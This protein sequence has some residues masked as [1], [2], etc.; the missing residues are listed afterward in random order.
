MEDNYLLKHADGAQSE[1]VEVARILNSRRIVGGTFLAGTALLSIGVLIGSATIFMLFPRIGVGLFATQKRHGLAMAGFSERVEL[2]QHGRIRDN[3]QVVMRIILGPKGSPRRSPPAVPILWRGSVYDQYANGSWTHSSYVS[4]RPRPVY[5]SQGLFVMLD[6]APGVKQ[7]LEPRRG[8]DPAR[9]RRSLLRQRI[10]LEPLA[11][12][13]IFG[14]DRPV[15][16]DVPRRKLSRRRLF[17]PQRGPLG[18]IRARRRRTTGALYIA[19]SKRYRPTPELMRQAAP[20][21]RPEM[22]PFLRL[23]REVPARVRDLARRITAGKQTVYDKVQAVMSYLQTRHRYTLELEHRKGREP[24]DEFLFETRRGHCEYFASSM[25]ILLRAVG[26]HT[27]H[28]NGFSGGKWNSFGNYLAVR[29]GDAHAWTEV[30]FSNLGWIAFDPTPS[31][32]QTRDKGGGVLGALRQMIDALRLRW[33]NH[34]VEYDIGKQLRLF[35]RIKRFVQGKPKR[36]SSSLLSL[37]RRPL[38]VGAVVL[39]IGGVLLLLRR[40]GWRLR[41]QAAPGRRRHQRHPASKLYARALAALAKANVLR[42]PGMTA[43][44]LERA[45]AARGHPCAE[46]VRQLG[47]CYD[48]CRFAEVV[49]D[50]QLRRLETLV[51]QLRAELAR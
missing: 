18:E 13:V 19:Y 39:G 45:L 2:G 41:R 26:I 16:L 17:T 14:A 25:A 3:P 6:H 31:Q 50:E 40:R 43:A 24:I 34:V 15:A 4:G 12:R 37:Y 51:H 7:P 35:S 22:A 38:I 48:A 29:Q 49:D 27:R 5:P 42:P 11:S 44:E 21:R 32:G 20:E 30:W 28:V 23:P 46:L 10:Y 9:L 1:K 33:F 47:S 36:D 8:L